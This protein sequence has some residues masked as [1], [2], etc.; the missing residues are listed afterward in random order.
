MGVNVAVGRGVGVGVSV[1]MGVTVGVAVG[2]GVF[3]GDG[4]GVAGIGTRTSADSSQG[5]RERPSDS[6]NL[7]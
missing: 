7:R 4:V 5:P 6:F 3:V 1:G 2:L